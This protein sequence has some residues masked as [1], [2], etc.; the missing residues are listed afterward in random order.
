MQALID[1]AVFGNSVGELGICKVIARRVLDQWQA[2]RGVAVDFVGADVDENGTGTISP[3]AFQQIQRA[4]CVDIKIIVRPLRGQIVTRLSRGMND[5]VRAGRANEREHPVAVSDIEVLM[6]VCRKFS[7]ELIEH[8][9]GIAFGPEEH[10]AVVARSHYRGWTT[11][12]IAA[13][14]GIAEGTVKS[15]LHYALRSLR[16]ALAEMGVVQ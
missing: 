4:G 16:Q 1:G 13:D 8:P 6:S 10:R 3:R 5:Q 12:Q 15:R 7:A 2:I 9:T 14:L 11:S